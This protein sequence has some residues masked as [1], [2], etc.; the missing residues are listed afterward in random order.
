MLCNIILILKWEFLTDTYYYMVEFWKQGEWKEVLEATYH[1]T[2]LMEN[3]QTGKFIKIERK[4]EEE[5]KWRAAANGYS[6]FEECGTCFAVWW[7]LWV[8][9]IV[10]NILKATESTES[11]ILWYEN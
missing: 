2:S 7:W 5:E 9:N 8:Y 4:I 3:I 1:S 11:T 6:D 10:N